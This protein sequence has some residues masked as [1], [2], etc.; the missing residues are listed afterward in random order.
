[1]LGIDFVFFSITITITTSKII[2]THKYP[3]FESIYLGGSLKASDF[4]SQIVF[5][6]SKWFEEKERE[7]E[8]NSANLAD[9]KTWDF[10]IGEFLGASI[11]RR[12]RVVVPKETQGS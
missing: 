7:R 1:M 5:I 9:E 2:S 3:R 12:R 11:R 4:L 10:S 8:S 6:F